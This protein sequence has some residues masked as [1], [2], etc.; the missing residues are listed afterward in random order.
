MNEVIEKEQIERALTQGIY[1]KNGSEYPFYWDA[2]RVVVRFIYGKYALAY[3][4]KTQHFYFLDNE[5]VDWAF[6]RKE[7]ENDTNI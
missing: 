4:L 5:G 6:T 3:R 7:L 1:V 2:K